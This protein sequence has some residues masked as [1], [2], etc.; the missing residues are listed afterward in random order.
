MTTEEINILAKSDK[1]QSEK[2]L[3][4]KLVQLKSEGWRMLESIIYV[5][6][7]QECT[8]QEA[9]I[10]VINSLAWADERNDF[11]KHQEEQFEEFLETGKDN[12]ESIQHTYNPHKTE[13][14]YIMKNKKK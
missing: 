3:N 12:V 1:K 5:K 4:S 13:V 2:E 9:Y 10:K 6:V 11:I 8:L 14:K 7:N